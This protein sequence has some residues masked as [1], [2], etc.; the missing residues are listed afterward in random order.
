MEKSNKRVKF[1]NAGYLYGLLGLI[2]YKLI[3]DLIY[4]DVISPY[5]AY[6]GFVN[7]LSITK[8][9]AGYIAIVA[10][11]PFIIKLYRI[12]GHT[13]F[14]YL[15]LLLTLI[16]FIPNLTFIAYV[17]LPVGYLWTFSTYWF[18]FYLF[19]IA[20]PY[21]KPP[22]LSHTTET[23]LYIYTVVLSLGI[24]IV[25][26]IYTKFRFHFNFFNVY[27]LR[28]EERGYNFPLIFSYLISAAGAIL[29]IILLYFFEKRKF[30]ISTFIIVIILLN[31]GIGGHKS[32]L[33]GLIVTIIFYFIYKDGFIKYAT[34]L[35]SGLG[36]IA[37]FEYYQFKSL[38]IA[39]LII[40]RVLLLPAY[41]NTKYYDFFT[42]NNPDYFK[43]SFLRY[44]GFKSEYNDPISL[45]IGERYLAPDCYANNG[46]LSDA[47]LNFGIIG[48][49]IFPIILIILFKYVDSLAQGIPSKYLIIPCVMISISLLSTS[50]MTVMLTNGLIFIM[51]LLYLFP[52]SNN[53]NLNK[54]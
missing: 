27:D 11:S 15:I 50:V 49:F 25:S 40:R 45:V 20:T 6:A 43:Q 4:Q 47:L 42:S 2:I 9:I 36:G 3:L 13:V 44:F 26:G 37:L 35:M 5:Y 14:C 30:V 24:L 54:I 21:F 41:L 53:K 48:V 19:A 51:I 52:R 16:S 12:R 38:I 1:N 8:L 29:P 28:D 18:I 46:L 7:N 34:W 17:D 10:I 31:F 39:G 23:P 32:V 22:D 33:F